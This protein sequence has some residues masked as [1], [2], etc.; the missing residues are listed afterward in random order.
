MNQL[1]IDEDLADGSSGDYTSTRKVGRILSALRLKEVPKSSG[2]KR[3][4]VLTLYQ[5][6]SIARGYGFKPVLPD[7][8]TPAPHST[9]LVQDT[10]TPFPIMG[11]MG[12]MGRTGQEALTK[13]RGS[14]RWPK[15]T[16]G[17]L[18]PASRGFRRPKV[19]TIGIASFGWL[20]P[21]IFAR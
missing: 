11:L 2:Q 1:A 10:G 8:Q 13:P 20:R 17:L 6:D 4:R 21:A 3:K 5:L 9:P 18:S 12:L 14:W 19:R 7:T 15:P 16:S